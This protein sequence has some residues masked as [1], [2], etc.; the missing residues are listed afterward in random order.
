[1]IKTTVQLEHRDYLW[2]KAEGKKRR[3][4]MAEVIRGLIQE[5]SGHCNRHMHSHYNDLTEARVYLNGDE[6]L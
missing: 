4:S 1:M 5:K 6:S 2:L 3:V